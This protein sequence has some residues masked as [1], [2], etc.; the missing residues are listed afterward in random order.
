MASRAE[1]LSPDGSVVVGEHWTSD[2][3]NDRPTM[4]RDGS[5]VLLPHQGLNGGDLEAHSV[6]GDGSVIVGYANEDPV[7]G[8]PHA[9]RWVNGAFEYLE[10]GVVDANA[11]GHANDVSVDGSV[12]VGHVTDN[13]VRWVNGIPTTIGAGVAWGVSGDGAVVVGSSPGGEAFRWSDGVLTPLGD[14]PGGHIQS[15]A[16]DV[17]DDGSTIVGRGR[18]ASGSEA[19]RWTAETGMVGLGDLPGGAFDSAAYAVSEDGSVIVGDSGWNAFYWTA[20]LG[21]TNLKE[22]LEGM[23]LDLSGWQLQRATA[24]SADGNTIVGWGLNPEGED[25]AWL[26]RVPEPA[27][28]MLL[29]PALGVLLVLRRSNRPSKAF[30]SARLILPYDRN[31]R[32]P[33]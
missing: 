17:S 27:S 32:T 2:G 25:E 14:L 10:D 19:F 4:W 30:G 23:G 3:D 9:A 13:A 15:V 7:D 5:I 31:C 1:G 20:T 22:L 12:I 24:V 29:G 33:A 18:S 11:S 26:A 16:F 28:S 21:M 8:S 6:S